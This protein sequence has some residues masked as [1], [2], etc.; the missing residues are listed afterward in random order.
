[1]GSFLYDKK[2]FAM[3]RCTL[4]RKKIV[5]LIFFILI[6]NGI[7]LGFIYSDGDSKDISF[8]S[9]KD[10]PFEESFIEQISPTPSDIITGPGF[11]KDLVWSPDGTKIA[12]I[13]YE[14]SILIWDALSYKLLLKIT[15]ST[16]AFSDID[17]SPDSKSIV[18]SLLINSSELQIIIWDISN[19]QILL[20][21]KEGFSGE[22]HRSNEIEWSPDGAMIAL[23][24]GKNILIFDSKTGDKINSL[25]GNEKY[26]K[27]LSWKPDSSEI[28]SSSG[29][30]GFDGE[31][32]TW[33][34]SDNKCL[35][36]IKG[37]NDMIWDIKWSPD[38]N[39]IATGSQNNYLEVW[40]AIT[41]ENL[42]SVNAHNKSV[43]SIAWSP[44]GTKILTGG[45]DDMWGKKHFL[46]VWDSSKGE[47]LLEIKAHRRPIEVVEWSDDGQRIVSFGKDWTIKFWKP[48]NGE[49]LFIIAG[50]TGE[51]YDYTHRFIWSPDGS[52]IAAA[53][54]NSNLYVWD[55]KDGNCI[56]EFPGELEYK[57][58]ERSTKDIGWSPNSTTLAYPYDNDQVYFLNLNYDV[59]NHTSIDYNH[60]IISINWDRNGL[61]L[62]LRTSDTSLIIKDG[63][64]EEILITIL[65]LDYINFFTWSKDGSKIIV[66]TEK[67]I[68]IWDIFENEMILS[69][70]CDYR[71]HEDLITSDPDSN[72]LAFIDHDEG[73][74][75][76]K[77]FDIYSGTILNSIPLQNNSIKS[78][79]WS[80]DGA[81]IA[82]ATVDD[83][84]IIFNSTSGTN[85]LTIEGFFDSIQDVR[86]NPFNNSFG[87]ST[88]RAIYIWNPG[89]LEI[90]L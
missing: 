75:Q 87:C 55:I 16:F 9:S 20:T 29:S 6:F 27:G 86:W 18:S 39:K 52:K 21:I 81:M 10:D 38:G 88:D 4:M 30:I 74:F 32:K 58:I 8:E 62:A 70:S 48:N 3:F 19:G 33:D 40:D 63:L 50:H 26:I 43:R 34:I 69:I 15:E 60:T 13:V 31:I 61:K 5:I 66:K 64:S 24:D 35:H 14:D 83:K 59:F 68:K 90:N 2:N 7:Y 57:N 46:R 80:Q 1:M 28:A 89:D 22:S 41:L 79:D 73:I 45:L 12:T 25:L 51:S 37:N 76:I 53:A 47:E 56:Y 17:W 67:E 54:P 36:T 85:L 71:Y 82:V 65:A 42:L 49:N 77:I 84:V 23:A 72:K 44:D 11:I 78:I